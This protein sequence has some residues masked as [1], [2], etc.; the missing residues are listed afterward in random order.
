MG[1]GVWQSKG[2]RSSMD[3]GNQRYKGYGIWG[4]AVC[5]SV[6]VG[7]LGMWELQAVGCMRSMGVSI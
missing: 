5:W 7:G 2:V 4:P 6:G 1:L 3:M